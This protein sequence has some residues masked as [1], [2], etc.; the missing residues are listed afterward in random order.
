MLKYSENV[1]AQYYESNWNSFDC[2]EKEEIKEEI[3][4]ILRLWMKL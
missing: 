2:V 3:K 4:M 1:Y